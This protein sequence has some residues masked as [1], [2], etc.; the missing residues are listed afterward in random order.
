MPVPD[1]E[2]FWHT[3]IRVDGEIKFYSMVKLLPANGGST[4]DWTFAIWRDGKMHIADVPESSAGALEEPTTHEPP[5]EALPLADVMLDDE[6][7]GEASPRPG[8]LDAEDVPLLGA[9]EFAP[10]TRDL[11]DGVVAVINL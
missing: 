3:E 10:A 2:D 5:L 4:A 9:L 1:R 11:P 8:V 7:I 6:A